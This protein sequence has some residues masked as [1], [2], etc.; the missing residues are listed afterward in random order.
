MGYMKQQA[1]EQERR[2]EEA[3][4]ALPELFERVAKLEHLVRL[5][6]CYNAGEE[7]LQKF[8]DEKHSGDTA[9][10]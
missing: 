5:L 7:H 10:I 3:I 2:K 4:E 8:Y 9:G 6:T 1:I